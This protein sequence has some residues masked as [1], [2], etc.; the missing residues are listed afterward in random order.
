VPASTQ[1]LNVST[2]MLTMYAAVSVSSQS[3]G[4]TS[5][6]ALQKEMPENNRAARRREA[7][8]AKQTKGEEA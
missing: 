6:E 3:G 8:V 1:R 4:Y 5:Q 7:A 2:D